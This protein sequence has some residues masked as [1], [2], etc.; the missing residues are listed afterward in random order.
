MDEGSEYRNI[1]RKAKI[2]V[3]RMDNFAVLFDFD[4]TLFFGTTEINYYVIN[5]ALSEIGLPSISRKIANSTVG[6]KLIDVSKQLL[7]TENDATAQEFMRR[8]A[9]YTPEAIEKIAVIEPDC[10]H[11]L[12]TLNC[13]APLAICSNAEKKYLDLLLD[14]FEIG[15]Y[16]QYVWHRK[17]GFDKKM[18]VSELKSFFKTQKAIMVG[19]RAEDVA[20]GKTNQ[21][22]TVAIQ[23][24]FGARDA[25]GADFNVQNHLEM[26]STILHILQEK[27]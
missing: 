15:Q 10:V 12:E 25:V 3:G 22:V 17:N 4:G 23:N 24:D 8:M 20:A 18:A 2:E 11:M 14:K 9:S 27:R 16:F 5:K 21:C 1:Y 7:H 6:D 13:H 26:E 19:D